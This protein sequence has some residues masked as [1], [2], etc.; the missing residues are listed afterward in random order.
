MKILEVFLVSY[1]G[2][3]LSITFGKNEYRVF[4]KN[5]RDEEAPIHQIKE[6]VSFRLTNTKNVPY[7][8]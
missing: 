5:A 7:S 3:P 2:M 4:G 8:I 6:G 1:L